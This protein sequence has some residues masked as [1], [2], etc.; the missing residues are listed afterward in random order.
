MSKSTH[1]P[2]SVPAD[3]PFSRQ[4]SA[5]TSR[6]RG[7]SVT[8]GLQPEMFV[9]LSPELAAERGIVPGAGSRCEPRGAGSKPARW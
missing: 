6:L 8:Q 3:E 1:W 5:K 2:R 9:E 7:A 4:T